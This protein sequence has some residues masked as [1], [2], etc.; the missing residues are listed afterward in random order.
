VT[1]LVT[2]ANGQLAAAL[3]AVLPQETVFSASTG[4]VLPH[5]DLSR[6]DGIA[7]ILDQV[8]PSI[9]VNAAA[10]TA[11][12]A[13]EDN[14]ETALAV[15]AESVGEMGRWAFQ[16]GA[17]I[18]HVS[19]DYVF[20]G[21]ESQPYTEDAPIGPINAYGRSKAIGE[22]RLRESGASHAILRTSWLY[23]PTGRNFF[24]TMLRLA[25]ERDTL[26]VVDDQIGSPT[27]TAVVAGAIHHVLGRRW[28]QDTSS[29][30]AFEGTFHV[31]CHGQTTW[32]GFA[33]AIL[34]GAA[35]R[36]L[37]DRV[38]RLEPVSTSAF[39]TAARRPAYS[40]LDQSKFER[41][42]DYRLVDW[43]YALDAVLDSFSP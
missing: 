9:I 12:D 29:L 40:V 19:T 25:R 31:T 2:G 41:T 34:D 37:L 24:V 13:A 16:R 38:P 8:S 35:D 26:R 7:A 30:P 23:G 39:P 36:G 33:R 17:F 28:T 11:V 20:D 43:Q 6:P 18:L 3:R 27:T 21:M 42:F 32:Y 4:E 14:E 5:I 1:I 10:Y 22:Q 15:N